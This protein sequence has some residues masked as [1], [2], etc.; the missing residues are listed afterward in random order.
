MHSARLVLRTRDYS[1]LGTLRSLLRI[2]FWPMAITVA[3]VA[4]AWWLSDGSPLAIR[5]TQ[6]LFVG[7]DALTVPHMI[8]VEQIR[9]TGQV[10]GRRIA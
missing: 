3:G 9:L 5:L 8:V 6:L 1:N 4:V 7:L 2:T 10:A